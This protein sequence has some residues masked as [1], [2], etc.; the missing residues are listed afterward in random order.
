MLCSYCKKHVAIKNSHL[1]PKF[2]YRWLVGTSA[3][4]K[5][6]E[7]SNPN[8]RAQDGLKLEMLCKDC[9][10]AFSKFERIFKQDIFDN[11]T[12]GTPRKNELELNAVHR[13]CILSI[14]WR[15]L[16]NKILHDENDDPQ[17]FESDYLLM[18]KYADL[19]KKDIEGE[20]KVDCSIHI[21]PC[22]PSVINKCLY[23]NVDMS[24]Y[25]R[26]TNFN[27]QVF[28][29]EG[30]VE[31]LTCYI[32]IPFL[33][34]VTEFID[35]SSKGWSGTNIEDKINFDEV[36]GVP[37]YVLQVL[38]DQYNAFLAGAEQLTPR[39]KTILEQEAAKLDGTSGS[40][41]T[42]ERNFLLEGNVKKIPWVKS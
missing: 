17:L 33:I 22:I 40:E 7:T 16:C 42:F 24:L 1:I 12:A 34:I 8:R 41:E 25:E 18:Q 35:L 39:Q 30:E 27:V 5:I 31:K 14:A 38:A 26:C 20:G 9:E 23:S 32:K 28:G 13:K 19:I 3:T 15:V 29:D 11:F 37:Q 21:V 4:G 36:S 10:G 2:V 6:R